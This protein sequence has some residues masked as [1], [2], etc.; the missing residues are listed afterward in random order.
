MGRPR[1]TSSFINMSCSPLF[2]SMDYVL[3]LHDA[4]WKDFSRCECRGKHSMTVALSPAWIRYA[5]KELLQWARR[6][7]QGMFL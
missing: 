1:A 5:L 3:G 6:R 2:H 7:R 4:A